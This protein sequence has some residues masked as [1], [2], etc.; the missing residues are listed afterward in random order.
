MK[1]KKICLIFC[2]LF[3]VTI[4]SQG[5]SDA[6]VCSINNTYTTDSIAKNAIEISTVFGA[7]ES[8]VTYVAPYISYT[9]NFND[10]WSG[11]AKITSSFASGG[12]GERA[13]L[14]D[15]F[16]TAHYKTLTNK[17]FK[18]SYT[19][20]IKI[21]FNSSNLK[22]N[23]HPIPLDYQSSLGTFDFIGSINLSYKKLDFISALQLPVFNINANSYFAEYSGTTD[24]P[25]T[26]LFERRPDVLFRSTYTI[27]TRNSKFSFKPNLLF[28]YHLGED[29]YEDIYG[30]RRAIKGSQGLTINGNL[31]SAYSFKGGS[32]ELS[33]ATP[34]VVRDVRPDGLTRKFTI[35][36]GYKTT[37]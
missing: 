24:F 34:F 3:C 26:N 5:C 14:G 31:I 13:G 7:G 1:L 18:W 2:V 21:P 16:L 36:I 37:F 32:L 8:D 19:A 15:A 29:T 12:F 35:G 20:G 4:Q 11:S 6:G 25:S 22:I 28:I 23:D 17:V 33:L 9:R 10:Q 30:E 27:E